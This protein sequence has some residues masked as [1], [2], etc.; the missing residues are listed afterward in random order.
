[1][2]VI[3]V[4]TYVHVCMFDVCIYVY[5]YV[6]TCIHMY[7]IH[8]GACISIG[9]LYIYYIYISMYIGS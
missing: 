2:Y 9:N 7:Y 5:M 8:M 6:Y 3:Y 4:C 1:M